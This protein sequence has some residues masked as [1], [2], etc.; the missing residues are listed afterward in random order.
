MT[1]ISAPV[2]A[3]SIVKEVSREA[4]GPW[5]NTSISV[6]VGDMVYYQIRVSNTGNITLTGLTVNDGMPGC[7]LT[8]EADITGNDDNF[9]EVGEEWAYTCSIPAVL[10]TNNNTATA[11]TNETSPQS[12]TA[13]YTATAAQVADP[14]ISKAGDPTKASVGE[15]VTFTLTVTNQGTIPA[16]DVVITDPLPAIFDVTAVTVTGA[17][18]G[19]VV[20][21]TPAIGTGPAPYTVLVTLGGDLGVDDIVT[22]RI[23]TTVNGQGNPPINNPASLTTSAQTDVI[24]N[25]ADS[26][27]IT[28]SSSEK[29]QKKTV[30]PATGLCAGHWERSF[31]TSP[32]VWPTPPRMCCW[33]S[34]PWV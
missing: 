30:L 21:V 5:N 23:V 24:T 8:R 31:P 34:P 10:G 32:S 1:V 20:D 7:T 28:I 4:N 29:K 19:T 9:F 33:K 25:N 22:I 13:S 18:L 11:D 26:V 27:T 15:T 3:L 14:A 17:P 12:D 2:P 16:T 6:T